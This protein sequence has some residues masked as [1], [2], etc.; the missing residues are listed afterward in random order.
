MLNEIEFIQLC[1]N[2]ALSAQART[3]IAQV[4]A[5]PPTRRVRSAG[6]N[7]SVRYPSQKMGVII[8]A[9]SHKNELAFIYELEYDPQVLEYYD[10]PPQIKLKY[11]AKSGRPTAFWH[12]PD[13]FVIRT[14]AV[15]WVECK[16]EAE[17]IRLAE[18]MP[19]RY[20]C[21]DEGQWRCPPGERYAQ[22]YGLAY[23]V[24]SS[25]AID[26]SFQRNIRFLEDYLGQD[27]P[28]V[29]VTAKAEILELII[30]E[31]G[32]TL[33]AL[34]DQVQYA[35]ADDIYILIASKQI[36]VDLYGGLLPEPDQVHLFSDEPTA[37]AYVVL[38]QTLT[39]LEQSSPCWVE[40]AIGTTLNWD[41]KM[42]LIINVG[43]TKVTLSAADGTIV[44]LPH[45]TFKELVRQGNLTGL[46]ERQPNAL[47]AEAHK[48]LAQASVEAK[49]EANR[50]YYQVI[51]P[52][53]QGH[54]PTDCPMSERTIYYWQQKFREA[55]HLYGY[56]YLG[57]LPGHSQKGNRTRKL[58]DLTLSLMTEFIEDNYETLKQKNLRTVYGQLVEACQDQ[59]LI[60]P[61][62]KTFAQAV[63]QRPRQQQTKNRQGRRAA[64]QHRPF[65]W[66]LS[67][68]TPR[69]GDRPF[70]IAHIDHTELDIE[71][72]HP[73][74]GHN[75]GRPWLTFMV[76]AFSRRLLALHL[77]YDPP[78]YRSCMMVLRECVRR[79]SR[80]PQV[81][82]VDGGKEFH[83]TYFETLLAL[84]LITKKTRPPAKPRFGSVC[85]RLFGTANT[86]FVHNLVG[87]TQI[88]K[89]V[90]QV[91]KA[92]NPKTLAAW[93]LG[94]LYTRLCQWAYEVYDIIEH[95]ALGQSPRDAFGAGLSQSGYRPQ[96]LIPYD[97]T[98]IMATL[99][100][101]PKGTAKVQPNL[102]VKINSIYY[103]S[104]HFR[105]PNLENTQVPIRYDPFNFGL[106][107]AFVK[108]HAEPPGQWVQCLSQYY[109]LLAHRSEKEIK[110]ATAE[111]RRQTQRHNQR[112]TL[113][114]KILANF[115]NS[116]EAEEL[117][118]EQRWRDAEAKTTLITLQEAFQVPAP[119]PPSDL[120]PATPAGP[121]LTDL[122]LYGDF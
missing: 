22:P 59:D 94:R 70:E 35:K 53:L 58:P 74:T 77:T 14:D 55:Q 75:L 51:E 99:P 42:W 118:T 82:V 90:R 100:T 96:R 69:H 21:D 37:Q 76:D 110:L 85:E 7:V 38:P 101:T 36:Y 97:D 108:A 89:Q 45:L 105:N 66:E 24:W 91:T 12:T 117:L 60:A 95:P 109:A 27:C 62:Y 11:M 49:Q 88:T 2:L 31:P 102:G 26:W 28:T 18:E 41:H 16:P 3:V 98:F 44:E 47:S 48:I 78:S 72:I 65:Y 114:A 112:F 87:N 1:Q 25:A 19:H 86:T 23:Q 17:L 81:L 32:I 67:Q 54:F 107:Y 83:S 43:Q 92:V 106:A 115:L 39:A 121:D 46:T 20:R 103:W 50:R 40:A 104:D 10:Q 29:S 9:E 34:L 8:Q 6:G 52:M 71:L 64:E 111:L 73:Q 13:F 119:D 15:A 122:Q 80:L 57:L 68:T 120:P 79:H 33:Q 5:S 84:Y 63:K 4:R 116:V 30:N 93:T 56:G 113:S 61:G